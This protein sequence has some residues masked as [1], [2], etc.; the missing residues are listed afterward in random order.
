MNRLPEFIA[1]L[2]PARSVE[3][4]GGVGFCVPEQE[5][6][7]RLKIAGFPVDRDSQMVRVTAA[8]FVCLRWSERAPM[9]T[10]ATCWRWSWWS[11]SGSMRRI[12]PGHYPPR[13]WRNWTTLWQRQGAKQSRWGR[14]PG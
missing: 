1:E 7:A 13:C 3:I 10:L 5:A 6:L 12:T 2:V 14:V 8:T 4:L 9:A 11:S